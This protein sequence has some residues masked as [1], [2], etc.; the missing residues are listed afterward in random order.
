MSEASK[1]AILTREE[2][3][4]FI[5]TMNRPEVSNAVNG[6]LAQGMHAAIDEL[7]SNPNLHVGII[8]GS[9]KGFCAGMDLKAYLVGDNPATERGFAGVTRRA[10]DKP[11]I[12]AVEG[13]AVAGGME[14]ALACDLI[15][16]SHGTKFGVPEVKRALVAAAG[17]LMR[18]PKR[19]PYQAAMYMAITGEYLDAQ[20]AYELGM[21]CELCERGTAL[22]RALVLGKLIA[23]NGPMAV[24]ASKAIIRDT[25]DLTEADGWEMQDRLGLPALDSEDAKEGAAAFA[26]RRDPVWRGC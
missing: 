3:G 18:L 4:V 19:V 11:L 7:D 10:S 22:E 26:E 12:A 23:K 2:N 20:R 5:I 1:S 6:E 8:T 14:I 9:G 15:V 25:Q 24:K 16:A 21:I 17:G 13:F